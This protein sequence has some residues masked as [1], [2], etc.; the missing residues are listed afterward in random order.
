MAIEIRELRIKVRIEDEQS[1][2]TQPQ[3]MEYFRQQ[4]LKDCKKEIRKQLKK[5]RER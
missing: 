1:R 2:N 4:V 3:D 5:F